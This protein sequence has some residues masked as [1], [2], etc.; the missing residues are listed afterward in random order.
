MKVLI[1]DDEIT[2]RKALEFFTKNFGYDV[3]TAK[4]GAIAWD[5]WRKERPHIVI[6]D[7][8]MPNMNGLELCNNIRKAEGDEYTYIII[9]T[10]RSEK[11]DMVKG[12]EAGA[13]DYIV[14]PFVKDEILVRLKSAERVLNLQSKNIVIFALA[15]LSESRDTDTGNHL[16][17][18]RH[19]SRALAET[20]HNMNNSPKEINKQ[21]IEDI[22][23]TSPLHDI[24]KVGIPDTIL[25]KT[26]RL[27]VSEYDMMK[28]HT[29][30]G[31]N[32]LYDAY[33]K[34]TKA[35]YLKMGADIARS[36]HEKYDGSGY[37]DGLRGDD[38]PLSARIVAIADY[39]DALVSKRVYKESYSH[40]TACS[41]IIKAKGINFEPM[42]I[43]VFIKCEK[44]FALI[45]EIFKIN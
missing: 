16:E 37:P 9:V 29:I 13:D 45:H 27:N 26:G 8:V 38:I 18:I 19:Y 10:G 25:L 42:I 36:H 35:Q 32:T 23:L 44:K 1:V 28:T 4:D 41:I 24:G 21:F 31:Y 30:I 22:F 6:T 3:I 7:W 11:Q 34:S 33:L 43:D 12:L 40:E 15:K 14:K 17:R 5:I 2:G 20:L 39:Y